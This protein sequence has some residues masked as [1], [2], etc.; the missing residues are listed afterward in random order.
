VREVG[1]LV[2]LGLQ[3]LHFLELLDEG[4]ASV[5]TLEVGDGFRLGI[6]APDFS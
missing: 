1:V 2:Q 5:V 6:E 4:D 3:S